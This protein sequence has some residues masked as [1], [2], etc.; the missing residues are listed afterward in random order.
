MYNELTY[1]PAAMNVMNSNYIILI[2]A[3]R[4]YEWIAG[5]VGWM[6]GKPMDELMNWVSKYINEWCKREALKNIIKRE[7]VITEKQ[8]ESIYGHWTSLQKKT[9]NKSCILSF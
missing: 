9:I 1:R 8:K 6:S 3:P 4:L 2:I 7:I 5:R